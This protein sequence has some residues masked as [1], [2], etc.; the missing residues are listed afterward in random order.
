MCLLLIFIPQMV[1]ADNNQTEVLNTAEALSVMPIVLVEASRV[2]PTIGATIIDKEMIK[3][4]PKSN[5]NLTELLKTVP[6]VQFSEDF[7]NSK[8]AGEI[9]PAEIS[10]AG[11]RTEDNNYTLDGA[12]N[13]SLLDPA[14]SDIKNADNIPGHSQELF[15]L[16]HLID[17]I[18][19]LRANIS[20]RYGGFSGGVVDIETIDPEPEFGGRVAYDM[21]RSTWGKFHIDPDSKDTFYNSTDANNQPE[22]TKY[23]INTTLNIPLNEKMGLLLDYARLQSRIP[24]ELIGNEKVQ[25][26]ENENFFLKFVANPQ[27]GTE[28]KLSATYAPYEGTYYLKDTLHSDYKLIGGGWKLNGQLNQ[29]IDGGK[30]GFNLN[31]QESHN[32]REAPEDFYAWRV[33]PSKDWGEQIGSLF[34]KEGGYGDIEKQQKSFTANIHFESNPITKKAITQQ[35]NTGLEVSYIQT[36]FDRTETSDYGIATLTENVSCQ[37]GDPECINGEQFI[38]YKIVRPEDDAAAHIFNLDLYM[39]DTIKKNKLTLQPGIRISYN[40]FQ[41]NADVAPRLSTS[42][43]LWGDD[44]TVLIAGVNRY[45]NTNSLTLKL[46]EQKSQFER[47]SRS[48]NPVTNEP[49]AWV[50]W[51]RTRFSASRTNNL[52]TPYS[53][54]WSIGLQQEVF[55]GQAETIYIN[56]NYKD[57]IVSVILDR[58]DDGY[59]YKE[60][61]NSG[62]RKHEELSLSWFKDWRKHYL[63]LNITW[64]K[65][66][67]NSSSYADYLE[68]EPNEIDYVWYDGKLMLREELPPNNFN[69]PIKASLVYITKLAYGFSFTNT[70][71]YRNRYKALMVDG[72]GPDGIYDA[73]SVTTVPS[74]LIFD[75]KISWI[76][77]IRKGNSLECTLDVL[78][79]FDRKT[80]YGPED[81]D[82]LI[83]RQFWAGLEFI[84]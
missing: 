34:S 56:R 8:T 62:R 81:N 19:V 58:D 6:G 52:K 7:E 13:N 79:V 15:I 47:Y 67:S 50:P 5:G 57:Q 60:W 30:L 4:L 21:T 33:S 66:K 64:Q 83:G 3:N 25:C 1:T 44:R 29:N 9:R 63:S 31:F 11:G 54:E 43:D 59:T 32:S 68:N 48:L 10:I 18:K 74:A 77:P 14:Y 53:D 26:R 51:D 71:N 24:L 37:P 45:Y 70:T 55:G 39:E 69:R 65:T 22:F 80:H 84:F 72:T 17:N 23:R 82:Y 12:G 20:A 38:Y 40:D 76:S 75:W 49:E 42:F 35:I 28:F 36:T 41:R 27:D 16:D 2:N 46:E 78:N 73:Y 61:R